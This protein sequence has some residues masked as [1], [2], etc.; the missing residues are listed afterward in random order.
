[1]QHYPA[2]IGMQIIHFKK[3]CVSMSIGT[4]KVDKLLNLPSDSISDHVIFKISWRSMPPD[5]LVLACFAYLCALQ[6]MRVHSNPSQPY[7]NYHGRS[8]CASHSFHKSRST[9]R[10]WLDFE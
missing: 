2:L 8:G 7:I 3:C 1:M 10:N 4:S 6:T 5:P 9:P